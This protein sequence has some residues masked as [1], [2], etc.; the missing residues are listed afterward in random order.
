MRGTMQKSAPV[1][2]LN[3]CRGD[4]CLP[5]KHAKEGRQTCGAS[6]WKCNRIRNNIPGSHVGAREFSLADTNRPKK[7]ARPGPAGCSPMSRAGSDLSAATAV[8][9]A[10]RERRRSVD[11]SLETYGD[12]SALERLRF[13][14]EDIALSRCVPSFPATL[15]G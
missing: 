10:A 6:N 13:F 2:H 14:F 4:A 1:R 12:E 15:C 8:V 11:G 9:P 3:R 5:G 7:S